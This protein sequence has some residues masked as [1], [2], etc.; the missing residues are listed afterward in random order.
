[1]NFARFEVSEVLMS[2][3]KFIW[4]VRL[5]NRATGSQGLEGTYHLQPSG[6][7]QPLHVKVVDT[8]KMSG[9]NDSATQDNSLVE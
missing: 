1:M 3:M 7:P 6:A 4:V 8:F 9:I 5:S 2:M